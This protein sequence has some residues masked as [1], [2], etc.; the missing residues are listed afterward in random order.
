MAK[1]FN[2]MMRK[3]NKMS[4]D[5]KTKINKGTGAGGAN[6]NYYG[7]KFESKTDIEGYLINERGFTKK[8]NYCFKQF[9]DKKITYVKQYAFK[10]YMKTNHEKEVIRLPDEAYIIEK[11]DGDKTLCIVEKKEQRVNGSVID[12]LWCGPAFISEY[13]L[14]LGDEFKVRYSYCVNDFLKKKLESNEKKFVHLRGIYR[15]FGINVFYGDDDGYL[16]N[17]YDWVC[18]E[19]MD[20]LN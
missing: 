10:K 14:I 9:D 19:E 2:D 4:I 11:E 20:V 8:H 16:E 15:K 7:K 17:I 18:D 1:A 3:L 5:G 13:E 12:K 6:T